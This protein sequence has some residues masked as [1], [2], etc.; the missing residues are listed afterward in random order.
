MKK[1]VIKTGMN[2]MGMCMWTCRMCMICAA[3]I[4][5]RFSIIREEQGIA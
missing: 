2:M 4:S 1:T 3:S 5:E